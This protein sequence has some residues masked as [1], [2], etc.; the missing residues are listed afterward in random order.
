M[1]VAPTLLD[2]GLPSTSASRVL[3]CG[4]A[5]FA[6]SCALKARLPDS[7][8]LWT[9]SYEPE[10]EL[11]QRYPHAADA[12]AVLRGAQVDVSC[13]VDARE[14]E[15]HYGEAS[16]FDR[17]VFNL[18]QS[19]PEPRARNQIQR[20]RALLQDFCRSAEGRLAPL[21]QLWITLLAGQ[22]GT[23]LDPIERPVGDT[24][25]LQHQGAKAGL[26]VR[27][28]LP[29]DADALAEAGYAPTGRR[30]NKK[31]GAN[32]QSRGLIAH[33]LTREG[34]SEER[35]VGH[36]EWCFDNSF[37][38]DSEPL[39]EAA[40]LRAGRAALGPLEHA[41]ALPPD[42]LDS[43]TR[44]EDGRSA[45]TYRFTYS[46]DRAALCRQRALELNARVCEAIAA[47]SGALPRTPS[48]ATLAAALGNSLT[49]DQTAPPVANPTDGEASLPEA[50]AT[51]TERQGLGGATA[52]NRQQ[53]GAGPTCGGR[54]KQP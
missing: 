1:V 30:S 32:R 39:D 33:V 28:A 38:V 54:W 31:L 45:R 29:C 26:L 11:L 34:D 18:P 22:G 12:I 48:E 3:V 51:P 49:L 27:A 13:G 7:A 20:H 37:W 9:S 46:S 21:G 6:Y 47:A 8:K 53:G 42:L 25:Q 5:D 15:H 2:L 36:L 24:W 44:P 10:A 35:A 43:Y 17:I 16:R 40:L 52:P 4:D 41:L 50:E 23:P 14:L 19:P